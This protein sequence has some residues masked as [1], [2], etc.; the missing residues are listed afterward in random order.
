MG[1]AVNEA[2]LLADLA[3]RGI[4]LEADGERLRYHPRS[5]L[6]PKLLERL[7][8]HKADLLA[9]LASQQ[10]QRRDERSAPADGSFAPSPA[11]CRCGC[12]SLAVACRYPVA[13]MVRRRSLSRADAVRP[14]GG[15]CRFTMGNPSGAIAAVVGGSSTFRFGME[16][17]LYKMNSS[18]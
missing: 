16:R 13:K 3:V 1:G 5:A 6:T 9:L 12:C 8:A 15:T 11:V 4:R 14:P 2:E 18:G 7:K 10:E 17:I